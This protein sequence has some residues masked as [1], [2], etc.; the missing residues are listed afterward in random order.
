MKRK[1]ELHHAQIGSQ[2][3]ARHG[4]GPDDAFPDFIRQLPQLF[5]IQI[6]DIAGS[7]NML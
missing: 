4:N 3:P 7:R 2:V 6:F 1:G 5:Q